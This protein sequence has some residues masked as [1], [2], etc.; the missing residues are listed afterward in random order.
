MVKCFK[1]N[2][3]DKKQEDGYKITG[4]KNGD[5]LVAVKSKDGIEFKCKVR[6]LTRFLPED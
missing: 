2:K 3:V 4:K 1:K 5:W 6:D